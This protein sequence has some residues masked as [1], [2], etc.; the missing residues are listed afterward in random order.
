M[1]YCEGYY[2]PGPTANATLDKSDISKNVTKCS[3]R[4]AMYNFDP[5]AILQ[6]ELDE[7]GTGIDLSD[8]D[9]PEDIQDG[10]DALRVSAKATFV[11]YCVAIGFIGVALILVSLPGA[12]CIPR[13]PS[14]RAFLLEGLATAGD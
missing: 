8:L 7:S 12:C 11:L 3:N 1:T 2:T 6:R 4:T 14:P 10:I 13:I 9:W 5:Q